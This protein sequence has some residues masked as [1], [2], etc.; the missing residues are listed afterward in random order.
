LKSI[1]GSKVNRLMVNLHANAGHDPTTPQMWQN[2]L[3]W[4]INHREN[5]G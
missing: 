1:Y 2:C 4:F 3:K 5:S